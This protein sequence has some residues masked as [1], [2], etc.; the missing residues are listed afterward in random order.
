MKKVA[1]ARLSHRAFLKWC[2]LAVVGASASQLVTPPRAAFATPTTFTDD[3]YVS[4]GRLG[5]GTT[6]PRGS[7][8][9][10]GSADIWLTDDGL[11]SGYQ[12]L[13][14]PGH[15]YMAPYSTGDVAYLQARRSDNSGTTAL[16]LRTYNAGVLTEA[17]HIAGNGKVGIGENDPATILHAN[18][19]SEILTTG[20]GAGFMFRDRGGGSADDWVWYSAGN[21][22]R[23]WRQGA[24]DLIAIATSGNVGIGRTDPAEKLHVAGNIKVDGVLDGT[25]KQSYYAS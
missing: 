1:Q 2:G 7:L 19:P 22:A 6:S 23:F 9:V 20:S 8:D 15:I 3:V 18:G 14:L 4:P 16:R 24:G 5:V 11:Q 17:M 12:T 21:V 13:Y 25:A 10:D